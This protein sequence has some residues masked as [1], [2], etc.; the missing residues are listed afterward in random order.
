MRSFCQKCQFQHTHTQLKAT[1]SPIHTLML[2]HSLTHSAVTCPKASQFHIDSCGTGGGNPGWYQ[3]GGWSYHEGD[4]ADSRMRAAASK[5]GI[6]I[7]SLSRALTA[8]DVDKF[9]LLVCMDGANKSAVMEAADYW[10]KTS[11]A[12]SKIRLMTEYCTI[13]KGAR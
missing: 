7:T 9:D 6:D 8:E 12:A 11:V 10:G 5:R 1:S 4:R 2:I 13:N 3:E